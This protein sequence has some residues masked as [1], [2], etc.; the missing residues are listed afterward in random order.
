MPR[1][2]GWALQRQNDLHSLGWN[3]S[4][5]RGILLITA[6]HSRL[7]ACPLFCC[8]LSRIVGAVWLQTRTCLSC[9]IHD[10]TFCIQQCS[11]CHFVGVS[12]SRTL[13]RT[14]GNQVWHL[15]LGP[16]PGPGRA[17]SNVAAEKPRPQRSKEG[18]SD[19]VDRHDLCEGGHAAN[20]DGYV[21]LN[22]PGQC[23]LA[24]LVSISLQMTAIGCNGTYVHMLTIAANHEE[25]LEDRILTLITKVTTLAAMP[26]D[27]K[28]HG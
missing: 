10:R 20:N 12:S 4:F 5:N 25:S 16:I 1:R 14:E 27:R 23:I 9:I 21:D 26:L 15:F 28:S 18:R 3:Q 6:S 2:V 19:H 13:F 24:S 17:A 11:I 22:E 7:S 8:V